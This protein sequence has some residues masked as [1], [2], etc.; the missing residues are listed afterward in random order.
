MALLRAPA[1]PPR[2]Y[3]SE[4]THLRRA[5]IPADRRAGL[6]ANVS[7]LALASF[8]AAHPEQLA[9]DQIRCDTVQQRAATRA[10]ARARARQ[11][12]LDRS[13]R[14]TN[15]EQYAPSARQRKRAHRRAAQGLAV[16]QIANPGGA[17]SRP[18]L[19]GC[20]YAPTATTH[21]QTAISASGV[22]TPP[23]PARQSGQT[24]PRPRNRR[25]ES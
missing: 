11:R 3:T 4:S 23:K 15:P 12:A 5:S 20:R 18:T 21:S 24:G 14:N 13:R 9:I 6:D 17:A 10:A 22:I 25:A 16:R 2:G 7:N 19:M 1:D 8:P